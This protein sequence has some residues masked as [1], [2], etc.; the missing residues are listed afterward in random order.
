MNDFPHSLLDEY[1]TQAS[2]LLK[3]LHSDN[4]QQALQAAIRFQ[5]LPLFAQLSSSEVIQSNTV[6]LKHALAVI[7]HEHAYESWHDFKHY[8]TRKDT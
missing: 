5:Q 1:K 8:L 6:K 7:A 4:Q 3:Q 2:I